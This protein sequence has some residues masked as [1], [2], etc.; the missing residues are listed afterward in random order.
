MLGWEWVRSFKEP[1]TIVTLLLFFAT[2]AQYWATRD[3]VKDSRESAHRQ[4]RAYVSA[5][6]GNPGVTNFGEGLTAEA[7]IEIHNFGPTPA[8]YLT[9]NSG[10]FLRV[11]P[12]IESTD[13]KIPPPKEVMEGITLHPNETNFGI[14]LKRKIEPMQFLAINSGLGRL[15]AFGTIS[16]KDV[17][18]VPHWTHFCFSYFG[19]GMTL[20]NWETCSRYNDTD[21]N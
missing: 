13:L 19:E 10:L 11:Y 21:K 8:L 5:K 20:N 7:K 18:G 1:I 12:L 3:L 17:F 6:P 16:Y 2:L 14:T 15:Y 4:L 9:T